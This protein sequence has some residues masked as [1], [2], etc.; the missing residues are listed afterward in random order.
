MNV[1][2]SEESLRR[3]REYLCLGEG[4]GID[5][6]RFSQ[7]LQD[8]LPNLEN[9]PFV[10]DRNYQQLCGKSESFSS[11]VQKKKLLNDLEKYGPFFEGGRPHLRTCGDWLR[12]LDF[13]ERREE[14]LGLFK[15]LFS[16]FDSYH[17]KVNPAIITIRPMPGQFYLKWGSRLARLSY[18]HLWNY[19]ETQAELLSEEN[20]LLS[21]FKELVGNLYYDTFF[22]SLLWAYCTALE[23]ED[24]FSHE[25]CVCA[26]LYLLKRFYLLFQGAIFHKTYSEALSTYLMGYCESKTPQTQI[27]FYG[28]QWDNL[29]DEFL[30]GH[31]GPSFSTNTL[32]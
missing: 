32:L 24:F 29:V 28:E 7:F 27:S 25:F 13:K 1:T 12:D 23:K 17:D 11:W 22:Q 20:P 21:R 18:K 31:S 6:E 15:L 26:R 10:L 30:S 14:D 8:I 4:R 9:T 19:Q 2:I 5:A 3:I 16:F